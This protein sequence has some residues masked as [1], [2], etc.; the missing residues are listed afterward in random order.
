MSIK[1]SRFFF[2]REKLP[3]ETCFETHL[4]TFWWLIWFRVKIEHGSF[5]LFAFKRMIADSSLVTKLV[6]FYNLDVHTLTLVGYQANSVVL[7]SCH[8]KVPSSES[9]RPSVHLSIQTRQNNPSAFRPSYFLFALFNLL[10]LG[11]HR[12][13]GSM[14]KPFLVSFYLC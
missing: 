11:P 2:E 8:S 7:V 14:D 5:Q 13:S 12:S 4:F 1:R 3:D 9:V 6:M 10:V